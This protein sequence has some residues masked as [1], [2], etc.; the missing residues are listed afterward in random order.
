MHALENMK[1]LEI[2][3]KMHISMNVANKDDTK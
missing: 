2:K 3:G 1:G